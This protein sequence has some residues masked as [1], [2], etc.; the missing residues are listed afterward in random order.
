MLH[1]RPT[2]SH[3]EKE[4]SKILSA[5]KSKWAS[6]LYRLATSLYFLYSITITI[7]LS[8]YTIQLSNQENFRSHMLHVGVNRSKSLCGASYEEAQ[9]LGCAFD[10][11]VNEWL[12]P[13]CYNREVA[14][15]SES[16]SSDLYPIAAG[17]NAFPVF[18]DSAMDE[19]ASVKDVMLAAFDNVKN[20]YRIHFFLEW[21]Y[22]RAHCLHLW[23]L[24]LSA[25]QRV[26]QG[27]RNVGLYYKAADP[28]HVWHCNKLIAEAD[29][30][31]P[32]R[33]T[34]LVPSIGR[35]IIFNSL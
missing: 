7:V 29:N 17:R 23:R 1:I 13:S 25:M 10:V 16:N 28:K 11:Y 6:R 19:P 5:E 24:I 34:D 12:P 21:E 27:E 2:L 26:Q 32:D 33:I 4:D 8:L 31:D 35:C 22:H 9:S 18:W 15:L 3:K 20:G 14:E 30:R